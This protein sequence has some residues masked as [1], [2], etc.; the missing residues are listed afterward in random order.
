MPTEKEEEERK[1][2]ERINKIINKYYN[3]N[4][5]YYTDLGHFE[6]PNL[7]VKTLLTY[8]W[9]LP[10][11]V[12]DIHRIIYIM[13]RNRDLFPITDKLYQMLKKVQEKVKSDLDIGIHDVDLYRLC[14]DVGFEYIHCHD[15]YYSIRF[16]YGLVYFRFKALNKSKY[17]QRV[18]ITV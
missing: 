6:T 2:E 9:Y 13:N 8:E 17:I 15:D 18:M 16:G 1:K 3:V 7:A 5:D 12:H 14:V 11:T 10:V 4:S